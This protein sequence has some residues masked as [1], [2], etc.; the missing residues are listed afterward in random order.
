MPFYCLANRNR[1]W[2]IFQFQPSKRVSFGLWIWWR[3]QLSAEILDWTKGLLL[4]TLFF[5]ERFRKRRFDFH[6]GSREGLFATVN[7]SEPFRGAVEAVWVVRLQLFTCVKV[8]CFFTRSNERSRKNNRSTDA[9]WYELGLKTG[10]EG[11][12]LSFRS[13]YSCDLLLHWWKKYP[14]NDN[15]GIL[16]DLSSAAKVFCQ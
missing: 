5:I 3:R 13:R 1:R 6:G 7:T 8:S 2:K 11:V 9:A 14:F 15:W 4:A 12:Y 16:S 10:H